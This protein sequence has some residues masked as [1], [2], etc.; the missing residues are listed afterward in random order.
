MPGYA[1]KP[2]AYPGCCA[3]VRDGSGRCSKHPTKP[4]V[5]AAD[6]VP[7]IRGRK[8]QQ[9]REALFRA[10]PLCVECQKQG[11]VKLATERDHIVALE[12]GG[13]DAEDNTQGLCHACNEAKRVTQQQRNR[14]TTG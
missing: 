11:K 2:C 4:W 14:M 10:N 13:Q 8:L 9:L 1:V 6:A 3:L 7:R 12:D 5:H